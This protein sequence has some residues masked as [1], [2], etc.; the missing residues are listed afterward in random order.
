MCLEKNIARFIK[1][2]GVQLSVMS[3]A[4]GIPY[5]ALYDTFLNERK[6]RQI[7]GKEL[8]LVCDFLGIDPKDFAEE[9]NIK[10][11]GKVDDA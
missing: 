8:I 3:R 9:P 11:V 6:K 7:R 2:K 5:T 1:E 4:T 10:T